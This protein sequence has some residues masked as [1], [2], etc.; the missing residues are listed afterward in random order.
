MYKRD[1]AQN[2]DAHIVDLEL[3]ADECKRRRVLRDTPSLNDSH[4]VV[5]LQNAQDALLARN[6][7]LNALANVPAL[8][9]QMQQLLIEINGRLVNV[10]GQLQGI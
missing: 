5:A 3:V 8:L 10:E 2:T 1:A 6:Q 4:V 9:Q 7:P